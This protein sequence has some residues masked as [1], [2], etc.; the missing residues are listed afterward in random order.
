M[1]LGL[2]ASTQAL[3]ASLLT[4]TLDVRKEVAVNFD[5]DL[6]HYKTKGGVHH[7]PD[8]QVHSPVEMVIEAFDLL[9]G[10]MKE[11]GWPLGDVMGV[12][13]A[14]QASTLCVAIWRQ[15]TGSNTLLY[16]GTRTLRPPSV[17]LIPPNHFWNR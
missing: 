14:G 8:G 11:Q 2:D 1:F 13:A 5:A 15:L 4:S 6:P 9:F 17:T 3:K 12:A 7:G 10:K 16:T